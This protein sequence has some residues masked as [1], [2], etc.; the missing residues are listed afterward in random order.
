[1][2]VVNSHLF[3][4]LLLATAVAMVAWLALLIGWLVSTRP[5]HVDPGAA[6]MLDLEHESLPPA[7]VN[8][9]ANRWQVEVES[10]AA[11]LVDLAARGIVGIEEVAPDQFLC[12]LKGKD[13]PADLLPFEQ[14]VLERVNDRASGGTVP[15]GN[16]NSTPNEAPHWSR[17]FSREVISEA[18]RRGLSRPRLSPRARLLLIVTALVPGGLAWAALA[19]AP[20]KNQSTTTDHGTSA[21][22]AGLI[23]AGI[24][25]VVVLVPRLSPR[26][27]RVFRG[28]R[29]TPEGLEAARRWLGFREYLMRDPVFPRLPAAAVTL[30]GRNLSYGIAL[31]AAAGAARS[32]PF[33]PES[34]R[35]A[36]SP[37]TGQWRIVRVR[38]PKAFLW[39]RAPWRAVLRGLFLF[40]VAAFII[41]GYEFARR[42]ASQ[43]SENGISLGLAVASVVI[44]AVL[45][46]LLVCYGAVIFWFGLSD[47]FSHTQIDGLVVRLRT[48]TRR[49]ANNRKNV[50]RHYA[51]IDDGSQSRL[52]AYILDVNSYR[53]LHEGTPVSLQVTRHLGHVSHLTIV[54]SQPPTAPIPPPPLSPTDTGDPTHDSKLSPP[55][56]GSPSRPLGVPGTSVRSVDPAISESKREGPTGS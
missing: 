36:W 50:D 40:A 4:P 35:E 54:Q 55:A 1:M 47:A 11:T 43:F 45:V 13:P 3:V 20:V 37:F 29:S 23:L 9:L 56:G 51:A 48:Y 2:S 52:R 14:Q 39:G 49:G 16:L 8:L 30:W 15:L 26:L 5:G 10:P 21:L 32:L 44:F 38:Y 6:A 22:S 7:V 24:V 25:A 42:H 46:P 33:G 31:G 18:R 12:R 34:D 53:I 17:T 27:S 28:E 41:Y 19:H